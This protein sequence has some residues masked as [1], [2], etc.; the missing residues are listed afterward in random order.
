[1]RKEGKTSE[2]F[3]LVFAQPRKPE[4]PPNPRLRAARDL[5]ARREMEILILV[6]SVALGVLVLGGA[7]CAGLLYL[8]LRR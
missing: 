7:A 1:M 4:E 2:D 3:A 6:L 8:L 5:G